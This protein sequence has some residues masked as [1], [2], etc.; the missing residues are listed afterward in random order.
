MGQWREVVVHLREHKAL[1]LVQLTCQ[2]HFDQFLDCP[3]H[4][5]D[6]T[7]LYCQTPWRSEAMGSS[8]VTSCARVLHVNKRA[9]NGVLHLISSELLPRVTVAEKSGCILEWGSGGQGE[10]SACQ[11]LV[12]RSDKHVASG[13]A[14]R[15]SPW[16]QCF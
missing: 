12:M 5:I 10:P 9:T 7:V 16:Q 8:R 1:Q 4:A 15:A 6:I 13:E 2:I 14:T 11:M 3:Q